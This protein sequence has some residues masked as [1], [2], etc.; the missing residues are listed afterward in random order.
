MLIPYDFPFLQIPHL[1]TTNQDVLVRGWLLLLFTL[2]QGELRI[3][4]SAWPPWTQEE[5]T[6]ASFGGGGLTGVQDVKKSWW[7]AGQRAPHLHCSASGS[8]GNAQQGHFSSPPGPCGA[9]SEAG[10]QEALIRLPA[11][12]PCA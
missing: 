11:V 12:G 4:P 7:P 2:V 6:E 1:D 8:L 3:Y 5:E 9:G 10:G